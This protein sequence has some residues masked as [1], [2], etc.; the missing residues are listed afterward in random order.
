MM[1]RPS[2]DGFSE[3][4]LTPWQLQVGSAGRLPA[5]SRPPPRRRSLVPCWRLQ[6]GSLGLMVQGSLRR[7]LMLQRGWCWLVVQSLG[8]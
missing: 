7:T 8:N 6:R 5:A 4:A 3:A 2:E 1:L